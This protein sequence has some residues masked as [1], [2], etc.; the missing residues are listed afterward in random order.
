M[1]YAQAVSMGFDKMIL[2]NIRFLS[3]L[4]A[5]TCLVASQPMP[6]SIAQDS[7]PSKTTN[8][9]PYANETS[10]EKDARMAWWR[11]ARFGMFIHWGVY[12]V[13]AGVYKG[14]QIPG[15][16]EWIMSTR[17]PVDE[18]RAYAKDFN[19][20]NYD[21]E[22]WAALAKEVGMRY[23]VITAKHHDGFALYPSDVT[24]WDIADAT[25]YGE[26]LIGPLAEAA[27]TEGI[28]FGLYFSQA[29]DW[30]HPG[31]IKRRG[32][33]DEAQ[34]GD[35]DEYFDNIAVPQAREIL[36]RYQPAVL[37]WDT[38]E[39][40]TQ[41]QADKL[42]AL[43]S[44]V[45]G[46]ITNNRLGGNYAGDTETPEQ[47]IPPTGFKDRDFEVCMTMNG[48]WGYKSWDHNWKST[49]DIIRKLCDISSK[50][51]NFL[52]N[53]GPRADG[54]IPQPSIDRLKEVGVWMKVNGDAIYGTTA[55]PFGSF[56]WGRATV[57]L[58]EDGATAYLHV[59]DWPEDRKLEVPGFGS[60]PQS[61]KLMADGQSLSFSPFDV[62]D[63]KGIV[64]DLPAVAPDPNVSVI[65]LE[66]N[67]A[68]DFEKVRLRQAPD[69]SLALEPNRAYLHS[70]SKNALKV[71]M[72]KGKENI[73]N[74]PADKSW[75]YWDFRITQPG[76]F[77]L[78]SE[79]A[80][81]SDVALTYQLKDGKQTEAAAPPGA[82][83]K[84]YVAEEFASLEGF[85]KTKVSI[86]STGSEDAFAPVEFGTLEIKEPGIY[87]LEIRPVKDQWDRTR[88][89]SVTLIPSL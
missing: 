56:P 70:N 28:K 38:P 79:A 1:T 20:V 68:V 73:G 63:A 26:D 29:Q 9:D 44:L 6:K 23:I 71:E 54:T 8:L 84:I 40:T 52:L 49:T 31:G 80:T 34:R 11:D 37:W 48:T 36:T 66:V 39:T 57:K 58:R 14:E 19:P 13:P 78:S 45:P 61:V 55:S 76:T 41:A 42:A 67:G 60:M 50:G 46:M 3:I 24:D 77:T 75:I 51:G 43:K 81:G 32:V 69:G 33:W 59:F 82:G 5:V 53:I 15:I 64:I 18:Y 47:F 4:I 35:V 85:E 74:W 62:N 30:V 16:G 27:R 72:K 87:V 86:P 22:A 21:P 83:H 7:V 89:G 10:E 17:I 12:A 25:P 65:K 88:L 2:Y